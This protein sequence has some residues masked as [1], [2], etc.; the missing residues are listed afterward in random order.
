VIIF[1]LFNLN[2]PCR[3]KILEIF[4]NGWVKTQSKE[5]PKQVDTFL[6]Y[7]FVCLKNHMENIIV[8]TVINF[9]KIFSTN[10]EFYMFKA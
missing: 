8:W 7:I 1:Y 9:L 5:P 6:N 3:N 2:K 10:Y 4:E